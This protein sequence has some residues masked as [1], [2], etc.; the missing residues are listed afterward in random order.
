MTTVTI[1]FRAGL[2][3]KSAMRRLP[4]LCQQRLDDIPVD[5]G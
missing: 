4:C 2:I 5:V 1:R 3:D